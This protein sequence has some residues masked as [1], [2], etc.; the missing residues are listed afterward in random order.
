MLKFQVQSL[1][2]KVVI[3]AF[4]LLHSGKNLLPKTTRMAL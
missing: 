2:F 4:V 3:R 1:K